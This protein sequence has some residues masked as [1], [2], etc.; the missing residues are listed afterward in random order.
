MGDARVKPNIFLT[1]VFP[2][3][4]GDNCVIQE[5]VLAGPGPD[6]A[7]MFLCSYVSKPCSSIIISPYHI[8]SRGFRNRAASE[9]TA[10][11]RFSV[12]GSQ[13]LLHFALATGNSS[14]EE[15][16]SGCFRHLVL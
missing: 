14:K 1:C 4:S 13:F 10:E 8:T 5:V 15:W 2:E 12:P 7:G 9:F 3:A 11:E 16:E 6:T